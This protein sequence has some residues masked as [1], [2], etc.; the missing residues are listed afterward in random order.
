MVILY[1]LEGLGFKATSAK[2]K[3][4]RSEKV[5]AM[6]QENSSKKGTK[7]V[8]T[9]TEKCLLVVEPDPYEKD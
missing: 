1:R 9:S 3:L 5:Q 6:R 2:Q 4:G 7:G 8:G